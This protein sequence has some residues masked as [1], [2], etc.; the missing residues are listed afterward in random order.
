MDLAADLLF[1]AL[2]DSYYGYNR[3]DADDDTQHRPETP[4]LRAAHRINTGFK[5]T[6]G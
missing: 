3:S 4:Q 1:Y 2:A 6:A 5:M